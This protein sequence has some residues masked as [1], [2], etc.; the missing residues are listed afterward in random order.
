MFTGWNDTTIGDWRFVTGDWWGG[1]QST[2]ESSRSERG[3]GINAEA[4][5]GVDFTKTEAEGKLV[6][7]R[8]A[9]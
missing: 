8:L 7:K 3:K 9:G 4:A 2:V 6:T 1:R 5:E